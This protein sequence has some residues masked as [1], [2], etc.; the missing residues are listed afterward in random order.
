MVQHPVWNKDMAISVLFFHALHCT[1]TLG[2]NYPTYSSGWDFNLHGFW[3]ILH[4]GIIWFMSVVFTPLFSLA[5]F[6][7]LSPTLHDPANP[8]PR[9]SHY[10]PI[11]M[12]VCGYGDSDI[13]TM[14]STWK[15]SGDKKNNRDETHFSEA[16]ILFDFP[17]LFW[18]EQKLCIVEE[19][20][21]LA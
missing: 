8:K 2:R 16:Q 10:P 4:T 15:I 12:S 11:V 18:S 6:S 20:S 7:R 1:L 17:L 5:A 19:I 9:F 13:M 21:H 3:I 14:S